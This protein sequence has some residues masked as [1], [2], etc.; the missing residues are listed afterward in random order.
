MQP[1]STLIL[2][3]SLQ[4][5]MLS[6]SISER[7]SPQTVRHV[8]QCPYRRDLIERLSEEAAFILSR[9]E[10]RE[11][12]AGA[13]TMLARTGG[14]L[15]EQLLSQQVKDR[16]K[17]TFIK[18]LVL[19]ID[20]ELV[21]IPW[22]LVYDGEQ[23][24]C[25]KFSMGRLISARRGEPLPVKYRSTG[26]K[27]R[28]LIIADPTDNLESA[29][30]EGI[31][32]K[33]T[34][35]CDRPRLTI[36]FK[37]TSVDTVYVKKSLRS[38]DIVHFAGHCDRDRSGD[39]SG[40]VLS[41]G[42]FSACDVASMSEQSMPS[43][44]FSNACHSAEVKKEVDVDYQRKTYSLASAFLFSGVRHYIGTVQK[45]EDS[46]G[47]SFASEFYAH[48][49]MGKSVGEGLRRARLSLAHDV[50][51]GLNWANYILYG[52]PSFV[53]FRA[54]KDTKIKN[55][56]FACRRRKFACALAGSAAMAAVIMAGIGLL[57]GY[58][59]QKC[60]NH[61]EAG[62]NRRA[63]SLASRFVK[64][65]PAAPDFYLIMGEAYSRLGKRE[66]AIRV[67]FDYLTLSGDPS[68]SDTSCAYCSLGWLYQQQGDYGKA[69]E[70][71][72]TSLK[73]S[74]EKNNR[75][76]EATVLRKLA[77]WHIDMGD[78][79]RALELLT[80][81]SEINRAN[82]AQ[83]QHRYNLACDYFDIALVFENKDDYQTAREFY[84]KS[85]VILSEL[86]LAHEMSDLYFNMGEIH[87]FD[88]RYR[89]ALECYKR[90]L[91][92][93]L[94][95]ENKANVPGDYNM[96]GELYL[97]MDDTDKAEEFFIKAED[98]A[99]EISSRPDLAYVYY[100]QGLLHK[101]RGHKGKARESLRKAQEIFAFMRVPDY[102]EVKKELL[103][104]DNAL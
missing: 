82:H 3:I 60:R 9:S 57:P 17:L 81:S 40:W 12:T 94:S 20:E 90:G 25:L 22:E 70:Y 5:D 15:W 95:Q 11:E 36:D 37:S 1:E 43:L 86:K 38:Y 21:R 47:F 73:L 6:M 58:N 35:D 59:L 71:Y 78:D 32:I 4:G 56:I 80:K 72:E 88:K 30:R 89:E 44:V 33:D 31:C 7:E 13:S 91:A 48:V 62:R 96:I 49:L 68:R 28:M 42:I 63:L 87:V 64:N 101:R 98:A 83:R 76:T 2:E 84:E 74:R 61:L 24:L 67:Y 29:Y 8:T 75:L 34:L 66:D 65:H 19:A 39:G 69:R 99:L 100:N 23:F 51:S 16:L 46:T 85:R 50:F 27:L 52:D 45:I 92:V 26:E 104:L 77:L 53:L 54:G 102:E 18:N 93:D 41:D 10:S 103:G 14:L 55:P 97:T 79:E